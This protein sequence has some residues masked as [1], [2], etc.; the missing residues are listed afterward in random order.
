MF[1]IKKKLEI[2]CYKARNFFTLEAVVFEYLF[3][4]R[5]MKSALRFDEMSDRY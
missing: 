3:S 4:V 1:S 2:K 5:R